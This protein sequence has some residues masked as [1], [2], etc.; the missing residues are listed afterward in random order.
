MATSSVLTMLL[1]TVP[2]ATR[3]PAREGALGPA[4]AATTRSC[5]TSLPLMTACPRLRAPA[6]GDVSRTHVPDPNTPSAAS[7]TIATTSAHP[8]NRN[9]AMTLKNVTR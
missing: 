9:H 1:D 6:S 4:S 2:A 5:C 8:Q 3:G 7:G